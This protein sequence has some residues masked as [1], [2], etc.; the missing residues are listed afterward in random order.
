MRAAFYPLFG[1]AF[2][3]ATALALGTLLLRALSIRLY[4]TEERLLGFVTGSAVLSAI[5][6][7]L[8]A[9]KA[10][11]K[12]V[13][14][15]LGAASIL[16]VWRMGGYRAKGNEVPAMPRAWRFVLLGVFAVFAIYYF[17]TA[18][19][20]EK[21]PDGMGYHLWI[22][23]EYARAHG[24]VRIPTSFYANLTQGLELLFLYAFAFGRHSAA[25]LVHF[26]FLVTLP[27]LMVSY[28]RR[29]GFPRAAVA[30]A[31][32]VFVAP[33][34]GFDGSI[35]YVDV[36]LA[37]VIFAVFYLLQ[38]WDLE[39]DARL[40]VPI[41]ILAGFAF[42]I[43]YTGI[44]VVVYALGFVAW[45]LLRAQTYFA[46]G[47]H[48][49]RVVAAFHRSMDGQEL[50]VDWQSGHTLRESLVSKSVGSHLV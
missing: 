28:G 47:A 26:T 37:T 20:P 42:A 18:W 21:S 15:A 25:A 29:F 49:S 9:L 19:A 5:L 31:L 6:F 11:H 2:F 27:F 36:A 3:A 40:L 50:V 45:K 46:A 34:V 23:A 33:V 30:A 16:A 17:V 14:L 32:F 4:R 24:F 12:G 8:C 13:F 39:R 41:G 7:V 35:A 22:V 43:K 1:A 44:I 38:I 48:S 10:A